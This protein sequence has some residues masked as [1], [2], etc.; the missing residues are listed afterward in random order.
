MN[1]NFLRFYKK[2]SLT[3]QIIPIVVFVMLLKYGV[4]VL[5][6]E[7]IGSNPYL[8]SLLAA[9]VFLIGFLITGVL[10][11]Y[12]ESEKLP[13]EL[14]S[15]LET[16]ADEAQIIYMN[17]KDPKAREFVAYLKEFAQTLE[18]WF[19]HRVKTIDLL[20]KLRGFNGYFAAFESSAQA[21]FVTRMKQEQHAIRRNITRIHTVSE[22]SFISSGYAIAE[23]ISVLVLLSII[24]TK[25]DPFYESM[26][27]VVPVAYLLV[28][29]IAL[30]RDLD[31][32]FEYSDKGERREE[33]SLKEVHDEV[34]RLAMRMRELE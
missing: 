20:D 27:F 26:F 28:Y 6:W 7:I 13:G 31:N 11:D 19:Y 21:T 15:S 32:P 14:A 5:G 4:H 18:E 24:L 22:T 8:S 9:T 30:I 1:A 10:A 25:L 23:G 2:W 17:K 34:E 33:V 12:K 29:M 16:L 3:I